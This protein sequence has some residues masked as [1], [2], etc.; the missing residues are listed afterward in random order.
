M[1]RDKLSKIPIKA[2][3]A[4]NGILFGI[5]S[6]V[7]WRIGFHIETYLRSREPL[8]SDFSICHLGYPFSWWYLPLLSFITV[9]SA[10]FLVH[11]FAAIYVK[12]IIWFWQTVGIMTVLIFVLFSAMYAFYNWYLE[13]FEFNQ[14]YSLILGVKSDFFFVFAAFPIIAIFNLLF[15]LILKRLKTHLP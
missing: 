10:T 8:S 6:E 12:S 5:L 15:A 9:T 3:G 1:I 13:G 14:L 2:L 4:I 7:I 11:H